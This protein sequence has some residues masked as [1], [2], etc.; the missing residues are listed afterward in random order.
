MKIIFN[1]MK[2]ETT[3]TRIALLLF[4]IIVIIAAI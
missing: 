1:N 4:I 3:I 2:S